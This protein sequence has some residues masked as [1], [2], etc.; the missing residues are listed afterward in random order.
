M[1]IKSLLHTEPCSRDSQRV[2]SV[3]EKP[4]GHNGISVW[5]LS[6]ERDQ[7]L[8][9]FML[10]LLLGPSCPLTAGSAQV[11]KSAVSYATLYYRASSI[12]PEDHIVVSVLLC[13]RIDT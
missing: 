12:H 7:N 11:C 6:C 8:P 10:A 9:F 4:S 13:D 5:C 1:S 2:Q 3:C